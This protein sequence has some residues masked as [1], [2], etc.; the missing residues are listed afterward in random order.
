MEKLVLSSE[1]F[2]IEV[3]SLIIC[4]FNNKIVLL[5]EDLFVVLRDIWDKYEVF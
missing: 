1:D 5:V 3:V 2:G 4:F